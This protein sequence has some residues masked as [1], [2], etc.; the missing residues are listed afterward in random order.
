MRPETVAARGV[1]AVGL[2]TPRLRREPAWVLNLE[3]VEVDEGL[4]GR[5]VA[6]V[7]DLERV[8]SFLQQRSV[9]AGPRW[10]EA[11][12]RPNSLRRPAHR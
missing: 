3:A 11:G 12:G 8:W 6:H 2:E 9:E 5:G 1:E 7:D 10:R 4:G